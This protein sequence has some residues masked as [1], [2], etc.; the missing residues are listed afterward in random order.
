LNQAEI[1]DAVAETRS[2]E[3][4]AVAGTAAVWTWLLVQPANKPWV[5]FVK[6]IPAFFCVLAAVRC[7]GLLLDIVDHARYIKEV[8]VRWENK[9]VFSWENFIAK[10]N[11]Y[12]TITAAI[13]WVIL[14]IGNLVMAWN[15]GP[16]A[17]VPPAK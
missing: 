9:A 8:E 5:G 12:L 15:L 17:F 3:R 16:E 10:R 11:W 14:I 13:I 7:I 4:Y 6:W 2:L 1:A